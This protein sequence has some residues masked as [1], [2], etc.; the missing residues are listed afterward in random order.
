MISGV[1]AEMDEADELMFSETLMLWMYGSR[2]DDAV[3]ATVMGA[4]TGGL[5]GPDLPKIWTEPQLFTWLFDE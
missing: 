5:G 1:P 3:T 2:G 4:T